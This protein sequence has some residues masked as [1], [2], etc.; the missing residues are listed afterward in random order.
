MECGRSNGGRN[1]EAEQER[2]GGGIGHQGRRACKKEPAHEQKLGHAAIGQEPE[3]HLHAVADERGDRG[4]EPRGHEVEVSDGLVDRPDPGAAIY[5]KMAACEHGQ[6]PRV[7]PRDPFRSQANDRRRN[8]GG[9]KIRHDKS[10]KSPRH[11]CRN[12]F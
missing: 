8:T 11:K 6:A 1:H 2:I 5:R 3:H 10:S 9:S 4:D 7:G 12:V